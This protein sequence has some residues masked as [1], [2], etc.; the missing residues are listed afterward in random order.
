MSFQAQC[1]PFS[2]DGFD[3]MI[4]W[5]NTLLDPRCPI[6]EKHTM[7]QPKP[8]SSLSLVKLAFPSTDKLKDLTQFALER[9]GVSHAEMEDGLRAI[10]RRFE[11]FPLKG[12]A[13]DLYTNNRINLLANKET[14]HVP[15]LL[16]AWRVAGADGRVQAMVN[17]TPYVPAAGAGQMDVRKMFGFIVLGAVL[18]D[19]YDNWPKISASATLAKS[20][21]TVYARAMHK[22]VDRITGIG[23]DRMRSDQIKFAF[24]KFFLVS[25]LMRA[26]NETTDAIA[27]SATLGTAD[28]ALADFEVAIATAAGVQNQNE[29]YA[30]GFTEFVDAMA[31]STPWMQ[32]LTSRGFIQNLTSMY[33]PPILMAAEDAGYFL[34]V[35]A[36]HQAGAEIVKG[37]GF[38]PVYGK[39][40]DETLDELARL[41]R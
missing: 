41:V 34:A 28:N 13:L 9:D 25:M 8:L 23:M 1:A 18:V 26:A 7:A 32:R 35:L 16:P 10:S 21:S 14:V 5:R 6:K 37:F 17:V 15:T 36:T 12:R 4:S 27:K 38:D 40:G 19:T 33:D 39:E 11:R 22:V 24:A 29:L 20:A 3:A 2:V 31:K 30:L